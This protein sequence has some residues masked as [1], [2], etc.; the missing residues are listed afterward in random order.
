MFGVPVRV[1]PS[2]WIMAL[3]LSG[4]R[5]TGPVLIWV[6]A[7]FVSILIHELGHALTAR[8]Y[9]SAAE[10][11]LYFSGGLATHHLPASWVRPRVMV[12]L[13]G[14]GAG[15][16]LAA[17]V[18]LLAP[19]LGYP[20][21]GSLLDFLQDGYVWFGERGQWGEP[22]SRFLM[23]M[24]EINVWWGL[25][26]LLPVFPLDGGQIARHVLTAAR[27]PRGFAA[28]QRLS[29]G[30][31]VVVAAY[32]IYREQW[33]LAILFGLLAFNDFQRMQAQRYQSQVPFESS[34]DRW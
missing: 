10:I 20:P 17:T 15:F 11:L 31:A 16:V 8:L 21:Q 1:H 22:M 5:T 32:A 19:A 28:A 3:L 6:A 18:W 25:M 34:R 24:A 26:N 12:L 30:T 29:I 7:V 13:A 9:G 27:G 4:E 14:P 33:Y 2:F 23:N